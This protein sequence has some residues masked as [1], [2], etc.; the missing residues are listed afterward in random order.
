[1]EH[2]RINA[3][4]GKTLVVDPAPVLLEE[5]TGTA[6]IVLCPERIPGYIECPVLV[7]KFRERCRFY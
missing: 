6:V 3:T 1:V 2:V 5:K 7:A 4:D